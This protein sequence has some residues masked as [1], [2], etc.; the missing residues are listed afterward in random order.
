ML[1]DEI[2]D[3]VREGDTLTLGSCRKWNKDK[4][5]HGVHGV[6]KEIEWGRWT[7]AL[8]H[9]NI[10][11]SIKKNKREDAR[12]E[13]AYKS[14]D[15]REDN[16]RTG[17]DTLL[18]MQ[19]RYLNTYFKSTQRIQT[20]AQSSLYTAQEHNLST[21]TVV[22]LLTEKFACLIICYNNNK[23]IWQI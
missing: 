4:Q 1:L 16:I 17:T 5:I 9:L 11:C 15:A 21:E 8:E 7:V 6:D 10:H 23:I 18:L 14:V 19:L 20:I 12:E 3:L 22:W 13:H 2:C